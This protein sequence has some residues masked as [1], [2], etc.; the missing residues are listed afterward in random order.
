MKY[1]VMG[2]DGRFEILKTMLDCAPES[3]ADMIVPTPTA[4]L[5]GAKVVDYASDEDYL[6]RNADITAEGAVWLL[7]GELDRT[8][9]GR[10]VTIVGSGRIARLLA[11]K[12]AALGASV[13]VACRSG[14]ERAMFSAVGINS[15]PI[16]NVG[17]AVVINTVPERIIDL[18][19]LKKGTLLIELASKPGGF[20]KT[21]AEERGMRVVQA[22]GLPAKYAPRSAAEA[23]AAFIRKGERAKT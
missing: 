6:A 21:E 19:N 22:P 5:K 9:S 14:R 23:I 16:E 10:S 15:V 8:V 20:D 1:Y 12:L 17:G 4:Q 3:E 11:G 18:D 13:T 7:M 2:T